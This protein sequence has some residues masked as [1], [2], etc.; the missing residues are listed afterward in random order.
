[1][2]SYNVF[3]CS[4]PAP[5]GSQHRRQ[6]RALKQRK[7][8]R[9]SP[10]DAKTVVKSFQSFVSGSRLPREAE[11]VAFKEQHPHMHHDWTVIRTK[12]LSEQKAFAKRMQKNWATSKFRLKSDGGPMVRTFDCMT[13][14]WN[15]LSSTGF[16]QLKV[17]LSIWA[18][19]CEH[20]WQLS[21]LLYR[22]RTSLFPC[23]HACYEVIR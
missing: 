20:N 15:L 9:W 17:Q 23:V 22:K 21:H 19:S 4:I 14:I 3:D 12:V 8:T 11:V 13:S 2:L 16:I 7:F 1:M 5:A 18:F 10:D 6:Q